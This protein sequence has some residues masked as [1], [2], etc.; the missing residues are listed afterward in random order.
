MCI[1]PKKTCRHISEKA[2]ARS[3][4]MKKAAY[5]DRLTTTKKQ[6]TMCYNKSVKSQK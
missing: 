6:E 4:K 3:Q 5:A 2:H 1:F